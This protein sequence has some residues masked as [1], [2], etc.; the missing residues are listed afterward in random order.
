LSDLVRI[1][2][3]LLVLLTAGLVSRDII[4]KHKRLKKYRADHYLLL[5]QTIGSRRLCV[6]PNVATE[7]HNLLGQHP[8]PEK[9][10]LIAQLGII[11][12]DS[13]D[14]YVPNK[15]AVCS[16]TYA[17]LGLSDTVLFVTRAPELLTD[18]FDLYRAALQDG[19]H[20]TMFTHLRTK[21]GIIEAK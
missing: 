5:A 3:Q 16:P 1:D 10:G 18:D 15:I 9:S 14:N 7:T 12:L 6:T 2:T 17:R 4:V 11:L 8:E 19:Q 20:V 13:I 21:A